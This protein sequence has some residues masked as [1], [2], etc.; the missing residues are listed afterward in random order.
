MFSTYE[1]DSKRPANIPIVY[2]DPVEDYRVQQVLDLVEHPGGA[3]QFWGP[4]LRYGN[5]VSHE[6]RQSTN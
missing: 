4:T 5:L 6:R 2:I 3:A 1:L